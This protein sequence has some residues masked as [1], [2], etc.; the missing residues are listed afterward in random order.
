M[1]K[2]ATIS[3]WKRE[4]DG[5]YRAVIDGWTLSVVWHPEAPDRRRGFS[6][7]AKPE[8]GGPEL[9]GGKEEPLEE[10]ENAMV[11]AEEAAKHA[12]R[13]GTPIAPGGS[14]DAAHAS[15]EQVREAMHADEAQ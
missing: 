2:H 1:F 9:A 15:K 5:S 11:A 12:R 7:T 4:H 14:G 6:W 8:A 13:V 3:A 10:I